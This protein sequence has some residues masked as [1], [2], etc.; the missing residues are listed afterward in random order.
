MHRITCTVFFEDPFWV[1]Y[2]QRSDGQ[3]LSVAKVVFGAEPSDWQVLAWLQE[4]QVA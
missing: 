3:T 2:C 4:Q 1:G